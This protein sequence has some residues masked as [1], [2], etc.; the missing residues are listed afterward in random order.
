MVKWDGIED[1]GSLPTRV[2]LS[3]SKPED[4]TAENPEEWKPLRKVD[5]KTLNDKKSRSLEYGSHPVLIESGRATADPDFGIIRANFVPK[6]LRELTSC[7]WFVIVDE[8]KDPQTNKLRN[9]LEP[10]PDDQAERVE[11]LYQ[12]AILAASVYGDGIDPIL[13]EKTPLGDTCPDYHAEVCKE[14]G[15]LYRMR[16]V[17]NGWF[18]KSFVLQRGHG[19]YSVE[20]EEEETMLGPIHHVVFVVH[21]IGEAWF[22]KDKGTS[23]VEQIDQ[24]RLTF[25]KR[26]IADWKKKCDAAKR[27]KEPIPD[28]PSRV[29][30]LPILWYDRVHDS[31]NAM[32]KSLKGVT[33]STIP[34]LRSI[35]N[36]VVLDVLLYMTP[37]Y[38]HD[39]LKSVT[40]QIYSVY[41]V[42]NKTF[43]DFA[44]RGGKCSLI[45]H[46]LGSVIL[47]DLLSLKK[48]SL[49]KQDNEH[50]AH[51]RASMTASNS[52]NI[53]LQENS[54]YDDGGEAEMEVEA[55]RDNTHNVFGGGTWGPSLSRKYDTVIPFEP[56]FTVFIG[57]PIGLFLSLR[58]AHAVFDSIRDAHPDK[59]RASP[60]TL[61]T[62]AVYN[63]FSPSDPVAYRIEPILL[64]HGTT[65]S[66]PDPVY[67]T[68]LGED[69]RLHVKALQ[70]VN[71]FTSK[72]SSEELTKTTTT[73]TAKEKKEESEKPDE[74]SSGND[75]IFGFFTK[76]K[77]KPTIADEASTAR[78][79]VKSD[80]PLRFPL[81]GKS[82]R[83]DYQLQPSLI[84]NEYIK[85]VTAHSTYFQNTDVIDFVI[86]ITEKVDQ[87]VIDLTAYD[88]DDDASGELSKTSSNASLAES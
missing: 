4:E 29:E 28:P 79:S 82:R 47:W 60:F 17:P 20:G 11:D 69:V 15:S 18:S 88:D 48:K 50:G 26:Q 1:I 36:D 3:R 5:C 58:G 35:A 56:E 27:K 42:F 40:D 13:K 8:V 80:G 52:A 62:K 75:G 37:N 10:M 24:L 22:S 81:G 16:K 7:T 43:P 71:Y 25:Q 64:A 68:R 53:G 61:P 12:R 44:S 83:L 45:G 34:A 66:V 30:F 67:L 57:S 49:Q 54:S 6:P 55:V 14:N 46:S 33:L 9:V 72:P 73:I 51:I 23:M 63:I 2:W 21:G 76:E 87:E 78:D 41:G 32:T 38:C 19:S 59:P 77:S 86:D 84:D 31:S 70:L 74:E 85:A 65:T 39:V